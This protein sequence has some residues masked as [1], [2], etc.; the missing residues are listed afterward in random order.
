[1]PLS[2]LPP[3][4]HPIPTSSPRVDVNYPHVDHASPIPRRRRRQPWSTAHVDATSPA[5][6]VPGDQPRHARGPSPSTTM[7]D[8][9]QEN[10]HRP[11][12][13]S[14]H[15]VWPHTHHHPSHV[16]ASPGKHPPGRSSHLAPRQLRRPDDAHLTS[17]AT[18]TGPPRA[19]SNASNPPFLNGTTN[20]QG[21][22]SVVSN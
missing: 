1:M 11:L 8:K 6:S 14:S 18:R 10:G 13:V 9:D 21:D 16:T 3:P 20:W 15:S 4:L 12:Q 2:S 5:P 7:A 22:I 17:N 19:T